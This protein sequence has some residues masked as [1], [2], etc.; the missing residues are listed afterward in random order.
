MRSEF[1][2]SPHHATLGLAALGCA[3]TGE[4]L[5]VIA[6]G[7]LY[8]LGWVYLPDMG[9]FQRWLKRKQD[10]AVADAEAG[11][12]ASFQAR[13][14]AALAELTPS[15]RQRYWALAE[16]SLAIE[17]SIGATDDPR[18]RRISAADGRS[19][20]AARNAA[21]DMFSLE[22]TRCSTNRLFVAM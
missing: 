7:V 11:E 22:I 9:F 14:D 21:V 16:V 20:S 5:G 19:V 1:F 15:R 18:V 12:L 2:K 13:R 10:K 6:G 17:K 4:P 8:V 3:A